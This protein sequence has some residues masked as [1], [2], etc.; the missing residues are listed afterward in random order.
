MSTTSGQTD[1]QTSIMSGQADPT[2]GQT[3]TMSRQT[4]RQTSIT[5]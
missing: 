3:S 5:S 4:N 2:G 1:G